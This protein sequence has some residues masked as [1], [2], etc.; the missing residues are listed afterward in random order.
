M[1]LATYSVNL[2]GSSG[3]GGGGTG[4]ISINTDTTTAQTLTA[5]IASTGI[6]PFWL[7]NGSG[8]HKFE[9]P[10]AS[11]TGVSGG[12][13]SF[14]DYTIFNNVSGKNVRSTRFISVGSGTTGTVSL[15]ASSSVVLDDFGGTVDAIITGESGGRPNFSAAVSAGG[16]VIATTF[17]SSGDYVLSGTPSSY[18]VDL[19]YRVS[20]ALKNFDS[21]STD[22]IGAPVLQ[23]EGPAASIDNTI[24][25]YNGIDGHILQG[26]SAILDDSTNLQINGISLIGAPLTIPG[27]GNGNTTVAQGDLFYAS[28]TDVMSKLTKSTSA[29]RYLTNTGSSNNPAWDL[30]NLATGVT[31]T[32]AVGSIGFP[33]IT[34]I[35]AGY[36]LKISDGALLLDSS[37]GTFSL[38]LPVPASFMGKNWMFK[39]AVGGLEANNV[40][41]VRSG[42]EKIENVAANRLLQTNYGS[43]GFRTNGTDWFLF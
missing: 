2:G 15:P 36:S 5:A 7:D 6:T 11:A 40:N 9:L 24:A 13:L 18:P 39:D 16:T 34:T 42:S 32:L 14:A 3:G 10:L 43:W 17:N 29:T 37:G 41:L 28:A 31:G 19:I 26:S 27:G 4:I 25:R 23:V 21:T 38:F 35:T 1:S 8:D 22:I 20:Q 33:G 30:V 12:L